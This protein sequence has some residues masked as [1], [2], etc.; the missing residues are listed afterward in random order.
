MDILVQ[1]DSYS[2]SVYSNKRE[3]VYANRIP[4]VPGSRHYI[5]E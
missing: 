4:L 2:R 1:R 3:S 5:V